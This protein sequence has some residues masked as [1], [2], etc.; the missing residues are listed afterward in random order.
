LTDGCGDPPRRQPGSITR[1]VP[2]AEL[3]AGGTLLGLA[4]LGGLYFLRRPGPVRLDSVLFG[5]LPANYG[6]V[7]AH[8]VTHIGSLPVL[9]AG[10]VVLLVMGL[11]RDRPRAIACAAAPALA[12]LIVELTKPLV[13]RHVSIYGGASYPSGTVT[14]VAALATGAV[15]VVPNLL[16]VPTAVLGMATIITTCAAVIVLRW[17]YPTDALGG[18]CTGAGTVLLAD[19]LLHLSWVDMLIRRLGQSSPP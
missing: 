8:Y 11:V 9:L 15:L 19:G 6:S 12:V 16:K 18:I 1:T 2:R 17:H 14:V 3:A 5:L 4:A 7:W 10:V 13:D